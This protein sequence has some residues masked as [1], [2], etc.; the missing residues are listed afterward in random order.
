MS[1]GNSIIKRIKKQ[2]LLLYYIFLFYSYLLLGLSEVLFYK[3]LD[4]TPKYIIVFLTFI[5][6]T[7]L[8]ITILAF[9]TVQYHNA[10]LTQKNEI[11]QKYIEMEQAY[12]TQFKQKNND[13]R[14]FRHDFNS[15]VFILQNLA[16]NEQWEQIK[17]ICKTL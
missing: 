4:Q 10:T 15:H 1:P 8:L 16:Q 2:Q 9:L 5:L 12:Y 6:I 7:I 17:P 13:L 11:N 3:N 14:A